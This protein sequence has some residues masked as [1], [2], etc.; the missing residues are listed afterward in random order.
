MNLK[1]FGF[2]KTSKKWFFLFK[3]NLKKVCLDIMEQEKQQQ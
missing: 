3:I 2:K 1:Y